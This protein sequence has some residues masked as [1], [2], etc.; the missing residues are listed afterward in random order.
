MKRCVSFINQMMHLIA[1]IIRN[2]EETR[3]VYF[4]FCFSVLIKEHQFK[5]IINVHDGKKPPSS[6]LKVLCHLTM[7]TTDHDLRSFSTGNVSSLE[8][9]ANFESF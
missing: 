1:T 4:H 6:V 9:S 7:M 3:N 2:S 8:G 5:S